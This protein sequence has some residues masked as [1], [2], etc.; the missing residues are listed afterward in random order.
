[1]TPAE[2][3]IRLGVTM[4]GDSRTRARVVEACL[5]QDPAQ[6][7]DLRD[8]NVTQT[9]LIA[10]LDYLQKRGHRLEI[11]A[12]RSDHH[13]DTN[14]GEP[15]E[16]FGCHARGWAVDCWPLNSDRA[17]DYMDETTHDF[18]QFLV[19]A[20]NAPFLMQI[21]L[22][23]SADLQANHVAAGPTCFSDDGGDHV[24]LGTRR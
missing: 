18:R 16:F 3:T 4:F 20:S 14:L 24:H 15:D 9:E 8:S 22:A 12:A 17:G 1:M 13:D 6:K 10:L 19:D 21:G 5:F 7:S 2:A 23:G 11:T